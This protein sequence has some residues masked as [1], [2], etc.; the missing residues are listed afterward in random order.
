[1]IDF[2]PVKRFFKLI[3]TSSIDHEQHTKRLKL[4]ER[5]IGVPVKIAVLILTAVFLLNWKNV[6]PDPTKLEATFL[7]PVQKLF[8]AYAFVNV[9]AVFFFLFFNK[10]PLRVVHWV[11]ILLGV[12]DALVV[13]GLVVITGGLDSVVYWVF[14]VLVVRNAISIPIAVTQVALNLV[15]AACYLAS[16][17]LWLEYIQ[18]MQRPAEKMTHQEWLGTYTPKDQFNFVAD[19]GNQTGYHQNSIKTNQPADGVGLDV[20]DDVTSF[21]S[22]S[23]R[24]RGG[25]SN[26]VFLDSGYEEEN[27]MAYSLFVIRV[28]FLILWT[29][30]CYGVQ[31]LF[32]RDREEQREGREYAL[33]KEQL[34]ST[35]RLAAEI[36]HRLKNPL[37]IINN[38]AFSLN[39]ELND[40]DGTV[41][42]QLGMI[43]DEVA[44]SDFI[45]TELMGY[46]QLS[47]GQVERLNFEE[48]MLLSV[49]E[50][51]PASANFGVKPNVKIESDL[52]PLMMQRNHLREVL[53]NLLVNA[54][55]V[56][57][58]ES[59]VYI[60]AR[61]ARNF[62]IEFRIKDEGDGIRE[63]HRGR[64][65]ESYFSTKEKGTG[66]GL[67]IVKQ[68]IELYGGSIQV[69]SELGK[70]TEF[71]VTLPT[72]A[73][74]EA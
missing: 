18:P 62:S 19:E 50:A 2:A 5:D 63:D 6:W 33:R 42:K 40:A 7:D 72:R 51:F 74:Q 23:T 69:E 30:L 22:N 13:S 46:A 10:W 70:G 58:E 41:Q 39:R 11:S 54:R 14:L 17:L 64:I 37:A 44:R 57:N 36:A 28:C 47:E 68:N 4:M 35:G 67:A 60:S 43:R 56:S 71:I 31:V 29:A 15:T 65:F 52:P 8:F 9:G 20:P 3:T 66:L 16:I 24:R 73:L 12:L 32:D 38:S 1:M 48:E 61:S 26:L 45:L 55:E 59:E 34:R 27:R 21:E 49:D 53:V 25:T